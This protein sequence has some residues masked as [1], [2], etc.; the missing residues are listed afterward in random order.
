MKLDNAAQL[1]SASE[2]I[3]TQMHKISPDLKM[4]IDG[5]VCADHWSHVIGKLAGIC[6]NNK[7]ILMEKFRGVANESRLWDKVLE[8]LVAYSMLDQQP[9][10]SNEKT[11]APDF[12]IRS[13]NRFV[14]VKHLNESA[15]MEVLQ[16]VVWRTGSVSFGGVYPD[17]VQ[18]AARREKDAV[19]RKIKDLLKKAVCQ[20]DS[21]GDS[22]GLVV[23]I[24]SVDL[25]SPGPP[26]VERENELREYAEKAFHEL[27][28]QRHELRVWSERDL[29]QTL[30]LL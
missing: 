18:Q 25:V 14:E 6:A 27:S 13:T 10:L 7:D 15:K 29:F 8:L 11:G 20:I 9:I 1:G 3:W 21:V 26:K 24:L 22:N 12:L 5:S 4:L 23:L 30:G 2:D 28:P 17:G 16:K 19:T